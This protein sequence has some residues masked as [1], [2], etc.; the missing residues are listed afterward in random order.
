[1]LF[2]HHKDKDDHFVLKPPCKNINGTQK[3][4]VL[5]LKDAIIRQSKSSQKH[6]IIINQSD[7][8]LYELKAANSHLQNEW[9][10]DIKTFVDKAVAE[11]AFSHQNMFLFS[12]LIFLFI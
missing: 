2:T 12:C 6:I 9:L 10:K 11:G 5:M 4:P 8:C 1:M 7:R 3:S